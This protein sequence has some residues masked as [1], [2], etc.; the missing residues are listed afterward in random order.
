[1]FSDMVYLF[2]SIQY[3][4]S[5][6]NMHIVK[7]KSDRFLYRLVSKDLTCLLHSLLELQAG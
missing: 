6:Y 2:N 7:A 5:V 3:H 4:L 1:M